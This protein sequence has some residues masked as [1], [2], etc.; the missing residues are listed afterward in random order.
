MCVCLHVCAT[1]VTSALIGQVG[2][3]VKLKLYKYTAFEKTLK[4]GN[5]PKTCNELGNPY[6][7]LFQTIGEKQM[8]IVTFSFTFYAIITATVTLDGSLKVQGAAVLCTA[9]DFPM[10][11]FAAGIIGKSMQLEF[12]NLN[13]CL[14]TTMTEMMLTTIHA[15]PFWKSTALTH[16]HFICCGWDCCISLDSSRQ[17]E[18]TIL[19]TC[20]A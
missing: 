13:S 15:K 16:E 8:T 12:T 18:S 14:G 1:E 10:L 19:W 20:H 2:L 7:N 9:S 4:Y 11:G 3:D 17:E 6:S 5:E